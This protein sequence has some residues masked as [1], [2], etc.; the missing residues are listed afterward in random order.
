MRIVAILLV[1]ASFSVLAQVRPVWPTA[2][3]TKATPE[4]QGISAARF[5]ELDREVR[6]GVYGNIDRVLSYA[7]VTWSSTGAT[8][9]TIATISRGQKGPL[10]CGEGCSDPSS[11][12]EFNYYHPTWHPYYQGRDIHTLQSVTKS[13]AATVVGIALGAEEDRGRRR[14]ISVLLQGPQ[15]LARGPASS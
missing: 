5:A 14:A 6:G 2:G 4:S 13:I 7:A 11:M 9:A 15:S 12:H 3:W 8:F 1:G 10:G